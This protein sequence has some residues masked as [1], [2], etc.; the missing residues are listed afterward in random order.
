MDAKAND[1]GH[2]IPPN[3][4]NSLRAPGLTLALFLF[5]YLVLM[6]N[7]N[8]LPGEAPYNTK[9]IFEVLL[10]VGAGLGVGFIAEWRV[11]WLTT[12]QALSVL[13]RWGLGIVLTCGVL[14]SFMALRPR[15]AF[16]EVAHIALLLI[17]M[18]LVAAGVQGRPK[19][20]SRF[21]IS[22]LMLGIGLYL[23]GFVVAYTDNLIRDSSRLWPSLSHIGFS[24]I[25][26]FNQ[27]Q[28]W[29]MPLIPLAILLTPRSWQIIKVGVGLVLA[30]WWM[31]LFASGGRGTAVALAGC[32]VATALIFRKQAWPWL[33]WQF[34]GVVAGLALYAV[35][36]ALLPA[37]DTLAASLPGTEGG[38]LTRDYSSPN[39][40]MRYWKDAWEMTK[41]HPL[42]GAG[43][44]HYAMTTMRAAHPHSAIMQWLAEWGIPATLF[45]VTLSC[46]GFWAWIRQSLFFMETKPRTKVLSIRIA[47]TASLLAGGA[48]ALV[49]GIIVMPMSQVL[50]VLVLGWAMGL[51]LREKKEKQSLPASS[52]SI[53][54]FALILLCLVAIGSL[55]AGIAPDVLALPELQALYLQETG[56]AWLLPRYWQQ[57][58][59]DYYP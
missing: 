29:T 22:A 39:S 27:Y 11:A 6:P 2:L 13:A 5:G 14:S 48:H 51:Y 50:L 23:L 17:L 12:V 44:M 43:P 26:F 40:R 41:E 10:L 38:L 58:F 36:F 53:R 57:G 3:L 1:P 31:L 35:L 49:S 33:K 59:I 55:I 42:L 47:L 18:G 25:R 21:L 34:V 8:V 56:S 54:S 46:R 32:L 4:L 19:L 7:V 16:L 52:F 30:G 28:T 37:A 20:A 15:F 45:L 9:R 24:H